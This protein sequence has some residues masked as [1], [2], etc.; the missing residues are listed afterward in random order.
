MRRFFV[1]LAWMSLMGPLPAATSV[2]AEVFIAINKVSQRMTI[3]VNGREQYRWP[4]ST[5]VDGGPPSGHYEPERLERIW[6]S[7]RY[8][9]SPMPHSIFFYKGYA[10]HGTYY[11]S[12]LGSRASHGCVRL[13]PAHAG[14][15]F[16]LVQRQGIGRTTIVVSG[17]ALYAGR[18]W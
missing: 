8:N 11:L 4:V 12:Q 9:W 7:R 15:L 17:S 10:I 13:H 16:A 1:A 6:H 14:T 5:G 3:A 18:N 2:R